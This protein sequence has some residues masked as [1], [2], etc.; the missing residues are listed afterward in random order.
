VLP[1]IEGDGLDE[2][3]VFQETGLF[4]LKLSVHVIQIFCKFFSMNIFFFILGKK[5]C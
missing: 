2:P 3:S 5:V 1:Y 4:L